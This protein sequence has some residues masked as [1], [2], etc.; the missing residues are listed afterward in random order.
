MIID[1]HLLATSVACCCALLT[2]HWLTD[3]HLGRE[4][5][6]NIGR[7]EKSST[8]LLHS[9]VHGIGHVQACCIRIFRVSHLGK[10][11]EMKHLSQ[12]H[13]HVNAD[14]L[15]NGHGNGLLN[16]VAFLP[17][18]LSTVVLVPRPNL[19]MS[20]DQSQGTLSF[21]QTLTYITVSMIQ[22]CRLEFIIQNIAN[23]KLNTNQR[24][25]TGPFVP[26]R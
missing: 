26:V 3:G 10:D 18:H 12:S 11:G 2:R 20:R 7:A 9:A 25:E 13:R 21:Q 19:Q 23:N 24:L 15:R 17:G 8:N 6:K 5:C 16:R 14:H 22:L 4:K 1:Y